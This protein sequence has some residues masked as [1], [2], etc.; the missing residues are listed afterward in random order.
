MS[1]PLVG[2]RVL[3]ER[4][5]A[6]TTHLADTRHLWRPRPFSQWRLPWETDHPEVSSWLRGLDDPAARALELGEPLPVAAPSALHEWARAN[7][8]LTTIGPLSARQVVD[9]MPSA[10]QLPPRKR[11]QI[12]A[13]AA[14]VEPPHQG[15]RFVD[16]CAGKGHLGRLLSRV[17]D[18]PA[19]LLEHRRDVCEAGARID[20]RSPSRCTFVTVDVTQDRVEDHLRPDDTL[21]GLHA[22]GV[23][24][25]RLVDTALRRR[26]RRFAVASCC[27]HKLEPGTIVYAP[28]SAAAMSADLEL[29]RYDLRLA[30]AEE[31]TASPGRRARRRHEMVY[32]TGL[33][34]LVRRASGEDRYRPTGRAPSSWLR[35]DFP[36]FCRRMAARSDLPL[37]AEITDADL[38]AARRRATRI[39]ALGVVRGLFR[40]ALEL[41]V[42]TDRAL[43][44]AQLGHD[45]S[46]GTFC[47]ADVTPRNLAIVAGIRG[48]E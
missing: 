41:W 21:V 35:A 26:V 6:L 1:R 46:L 13:M 31:V 40:R 14:A 48:V 7:Q 29:T 32:R 5:H 12:V 2:E 17:H 42:A 4:L 44:L 3:A 19:I 27:Y 36:D 25:D 45:V 20:A 16:W 28:R 24:T 22:C 37:P 8:E 23:L 10:R 43:A 15:G 30:T 11:D 34:A 33:D 18:R 9:V 38:R 39:R 47:P